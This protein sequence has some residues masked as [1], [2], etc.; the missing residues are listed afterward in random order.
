MNS[1][2]EKS[3]QINF[4]KDDWPFGNEFEI[5]FQH[6]IFNS[7]SKNPINNSPFL[8]NDPFSPKMDNYPNITLEEDNEN[9][10]NLTERPANGILFEDEKILSSESIKRALKEEQN[11]ECSTKNCSYKNDIG[12]II[13]NKNFNFTPEN[14]SNSSQNVNPF[15]KI[16]YINTHPRKYF[17]VDDAKKH[18]K[19]AISQ[20]ATERLN[21]LI[22][23]SEL[24]KRYKKRIHLP[25]HKLF[26]SNPKEI[27]N[28][29]F[30]S[31]NVKEIFT[32]GKAD[33]NLQAKNEENIS[34]ILEFSKFPEKTK[35]IK[36][37]LF[38]KYEDIIKLF[39]DSEKFDEFKKND[40]TQFF[41][42]GIKKEKNISLLEDYGLIELFKMTKK[43]R[44][45]NLFSSISL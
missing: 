29:Q 40:L 32:Y 26:S 44:K 12:Q 41:N 33:N 11:I 8:G 34:K 25:H 27:D 36:D 16:N 2:I 37:F 14:I 28:Y 45:R 6:S 23:E 20:F 24:P 42:E 22:K 38:L 30:L 3:N 21:S 15:E 35:K 18:F 7:F 1:L 13:I 9:S 5:N 17:R 19:V 31:F 10:I 43:K 39:Y 4:F